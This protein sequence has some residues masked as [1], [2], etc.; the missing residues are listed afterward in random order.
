M[1][2][3]LIEQQT[4]DIDWF[5]FE[6]NNF[7]Y[8]HFASA[9]GR[10]PRIIQENDLLNEEINQIIKRFENEK[11]F[12]YEINPNLRS[13][14]NFENEELYQE[15]VRDFI[16]YAQIGFYSYDKTYLNNFDDM[17]YHL[18]AYPKNYQRALIENRYLELL[19]ISKNTILNNSIIPFDK[20]GN[21][22]TFH[23]NI[24]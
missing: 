6:F 1:A 11:K 17:T 3:S 7:N 19:S 13:I 15:Y 16:N 20:N 24:D 21:N 14:M 8:C 18:V 4:R 2:Y 22:T 5:I 10:L 9:G 23:L 12:E